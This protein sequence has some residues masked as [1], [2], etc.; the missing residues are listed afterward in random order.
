MRRIALLTSLLAIA[1]LAAPAQAQ[2]LVPFGGQTYASPYYVTGEPGDPS[3]I[4]VVE[5]AG[6]IRV[7]D[8]GT[9]QAGAFLD[10]SGDVCDSGDGCGGESGMF[11]MAL[12]P[13]YATSGLFY[14]FY[15]RVAAAGHDL[16]IREFRRTTNPNDVDESTARDV[17]VI[18]HPAAANHNGGQLQFGPDGYLYIATGDGG[19]ANDPG[20]NAQSLDSL[21]GKLLRIDPAGTQPL[22][23]ESPAD[24]PF[25]GATPGADEI[26]AYGLRNPYRFSFD[27][28]TGDL[29][30]G[31]VGQGAWEEIDFVPAGGAGGLNFGW[32]CF[33]GTASATS[34]GEPQC[35]PMQGV[36]SPPVHQYANPPGPG[37][38]AINGGY[39]VRDTT[40]PSLL[41]RYLYADSSGAFPEIRSVTLFPGG[42]SGD[43]STGLAGG[44]SSFGEDACGHVYVA[45]FDGTVSRI[46]QSTAEPACAPPPAAVTPLP[47]LPPTACPG[48]PGCDAHGPLLELQ[49]GKARRAAKRGKVTVVLS[50]SEGCTVRASGK[51]VLAGRD[52]GLD[53]DQETLPA[54]RKGALSLDLSRNERRRLRRK[55][56]R[57]RKARAALDLVASDPLGNE[58]IVEPR[59]RQRR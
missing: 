35:N 8:D 39:V 14:V 55:L 7:V 12:A 43:A 59:V 45:H 42:A 56:A 3:R 34:S 41:G 26:Y 17:L 33:E 32:D 25:A 31:D 48:S 46:Q 11:S 37:N 19:G 27:R 54:W 15:T 53:P 21:L 30:I 13:D 40:V 4:Y 50:C 18:P 1:L 16:V 36:H 49:L 38:A 24:N 23:Y 6:R 44:T 20:G 47:P 29:I 9:T 22:E 10:V 52:I 2:Q 57:G 28:L 5:A 58:G 51:I